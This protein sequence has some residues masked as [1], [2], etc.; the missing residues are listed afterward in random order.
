MSETNPALG[1]AI[2]DADYDR[3]LDILKTKNSIKLT[4][5]DK[6]EKKFYL[7]NGILYADS[8]ADTT[9]VTE[10]VFKASTVMQQQGP[11]FRE[12]VRQRMIRDHPEWHTED[13]EANAD[14]VNEANETIK[15]LIQRGVDFATAV[16]VVKYT[17]TSDNIDEEAKNIE[18]LIAS[19][20][21]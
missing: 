13:V 5:K 10:E 1:V 2:P 6:I 21:H 3:I 9:K 15:R 17:L 16:G 8:W 7:K 14:I 19:N 4:N 12:S 11:T 18:M 20:P